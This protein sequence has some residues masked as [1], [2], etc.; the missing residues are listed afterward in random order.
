[1]R[2]IVK[3][4]RGQTI[5][6]IMECGDRSNVTDEYGRNLGYYSKSQD[7]TFDRSGKCIGFGDLVRMLLHC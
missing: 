3:G 1:M 2:E 5:G 7:K 6:Y 4:A